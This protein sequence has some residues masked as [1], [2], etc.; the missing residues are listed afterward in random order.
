[1]GSSKKHKKDHKHRKHKRSSPA[2]DDEERDESH[3]PEEKKRRRHDDVETEKSYSKQKKHK[4]KH[5]KQS[6][7]DRDSESPQKLESERNGKS[8]Q[9]HAEPTPTSANGEG[10]SLSIEETNKLR[11][12]LGLKPLDVG[13]SSGNATESKK[14][15]FVHA[16]AEDLWEKK[17]QDDIR[18]KLRAIKEK[19]NLNKKMGKI[20]T[21]GEENEDENDAVSWVERSRKME[22]QKKVAEKREQEMAKMDAE[23]GIGGLIDN[24]FADVKKDSYTS[25]DLQGITVKHSLEMFKEGRS[26]ILTLEDK[27]IL[28]EDKDDVLVGVNLVDT[29]KA[30]RNLDVKSKG[31]GYKAY[32]E[33]EVDEMGFFK[34]KS[35]LSKY[36]EEIEGIKQEKFT[37]GNYGKVDTT[38]EQQKMMMKNEI[39]A[40]GVSLALPQLKIASEYLTEEEMTKFKKRKKKVRKVRKRDL[41]PDDLQPLPGSSTSSDFGSRSRNQRGN[42]PGWD[43]GIESAKVDDTSIT[44]TTLMNSKKN[45]IFDEDD[46]SNELQKALDKA[47]RAK[48]VK[49]NMV[50]EDVGASKVVEHLDLLNKVS[51]ENPM[52]NYSTTISL[53]STDEFCRQLGTAS[54]LNVIK[55]VPME[56]TSMDDSVDMDVE[57]EEEE[58]VT[59]GWNF[60]NDKAKVKPVTQAEP[61][62]DRHAP[63]EAEPLAVGGLAGALKLA[64][65]KG[66]L[67]EEKPKSSVTITSKNIDL[68]SANYSIEDKN[69]VDHLDKYAHEKYSKDRSNRYDRGIVMDF[70]EKKNYKP[71][72]TIEYVDEGGRL[73]N[74]KEAFRKLSHRFHGKGS[75][76]MK[77]EKRQKKKGEEDMML[78]MSSTDTPL[79]TVAMMKEK[80]QSEASPYIVLSGAGK[81]LQAGGG[82]LKK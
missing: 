29:E 79:N 61:V 3:S 42:I 9:H 59:S 69:A 60:V 53:N 25:R 44:S 49:S 47:R 74:P 12:K 19:R 22:K 35:M 6:E 46:A 33:E 38:W 73:M 64:T 81:T 15:E 41:K 28:E 26:E 67:M 39:K 70:E 24:E 82:G 72:V 31:S 78:K 14:E 5:K 77:L 20:K 54:D 56:E 18:E 75:G 58:E 30:K 66:Y 4:K 52:A 50:T 57:D 55:E 32:D 2:Y 43:E 51:F 40:K 8:R 23:F 65:R 48:Q 16:P 27:N 62:D 17:K 37:I 36:D 68:L 11:L 71:K 13:G 76:K 10:D 21:L 45:V 34:Q 7:R 63:I 1:M 80:L